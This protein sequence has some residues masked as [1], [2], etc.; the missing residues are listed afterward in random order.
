MIMIRNSIDNTNMHVIALGVRNAAIYDFTSGKVYSVNGAGKESLQ[1]IKNH[2]EKLASQD[3]EFAEQLK[4][5]GISNYAIDERCDEGRFVNNESI[6]IEFISMEIT[7]RCNLNCQHCAGNF[8]PKKDE[9]LVPLECQKEAIKEAKRMGAQKIQF[10]GGEPFLSDRLFPL[11]NLAQEVGFSNIEIFSNGTL[12]NDKI[13]EKFMKKNV[14][15]SISLYSHDAATH[16][17]I[18]RRKGSFAKTYDALI[19]LKKKGVKIRL[20]TVIMRQNQNDIE[21]TKTLSNEIGANEYSLDVVRPIGRGKDPSIFPTKKEFKNYWV[22]DTP[23]FKTSKESYMRFKKGN[24]CW[25]NCVSITAS[26]DLL[27]CSFA[28][29]LVGGNIKEYSLKQAIR[30]TLLKY[31]YLSNDKIKICQDCE[32]RYCCFVCGAIALSDNQNIQCNYDPYTGIWQK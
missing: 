27:P 28:R 29:N 21:L 16:D 15:L 7:S 22:K 6:S 18:T 17:S 30:N 8:C 11:I 9:K 4:T 24:I 12:I 23:D 32:F 1:R 2:K 10:I 13:C 3:K 19:R 5:L 25:Q 14:T 20:S 26:G 31:W